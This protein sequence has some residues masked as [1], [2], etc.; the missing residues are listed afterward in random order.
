[1]PSG[2]T[3]HRVSSP[4]LVLPADKV[5][6]SAAPQEGNQP[7]LE[8]SPGF[9]RLRLE[10][11]SGFDRH[12]RPLLGPPVTLSCPLSLLDLMVFLPQASAP[13]SQCWPCA[14]L[15]DT[16]LGTTDSDAEL[17]EFRRANKQRRPPKSPR[18]LSVFASSGCR[19]AAGSHRL[20]RHSNYLL[21]WR[22]EVQ[23]GNP[24][25]KTT[26]SSGC[27]PPYLSGEISPSPSQASTNPSHLQSR[28]SQLSS[29]PSSSHMCPGCVFLPPCLA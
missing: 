24:G 16:S 28:Q 13:I 12:F 23:T 14:W 2:Q 29:G 11:G 6:R 9:C 1:M 19:A 18:I 21:F 22:S 8:P 5:A 25:I 10:R 27:V 3:D 15:R 26:V 7:S 4:G 17:A 20:N